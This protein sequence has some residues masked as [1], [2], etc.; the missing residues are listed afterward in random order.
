MKRISFLLSV[1]FLFLLGNMSCFASSSNGAVENSDNNSNEV[2]SEPLGMLK[3]F[4]LEGRIKSLSFMDDNYMACSYQFDLNGNLLDYPDY[5]GGKAIAN[6]IPFKLTI[7]DWKWT[8]MK[9]GAYTQY[10]M[11]DYDEK[12]RPV[13]A[14]LIIDDKIGK[15]NLAISY[16]GSDEKGNYTGIHFDNKNVRYDASMGYPELCSTVSVKITYWPEDASVKDV[17]TRLSEDEMIRIICEANRKNLSV[18][19]ND[20]KKIAENDVEVDELCWLSEN[21]D[22]YGGGPRKTTI[23]DYGEGTYVPDIVVKLSNIYIHD[24]RDGA[25][26]KFYYT[27]RYDNGTYD[28]S[29][30]ENDDYLVMA[31]F[32]YEDGKWKFDDMRWE[33]RD[34]QGHYESTKSYK[35][36]LKEKV[37]AYNDYIEYG[38]LER[39]I[40]SNSANDSDISEKLEKVIAYKKKY[41]LK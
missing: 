32:V 34:W 11:L 24:S 25:N 40:R 30:L 7:Y 2:K 8:E 31:I 6:E 38:A 28:K 21:N 35:E 29:D 13:S 1:L 27:E 36:T 3:A 9:Y 15:K 23:L 10:K 16:T 14:D 39:D 4:G 5:K 26:A 37:D 22:E 12:N 20:L 33:I 18:F 17:P 19:S 41:N